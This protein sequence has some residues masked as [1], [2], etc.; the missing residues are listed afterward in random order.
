MLGKKE[1]LF[2]P[3][4]SLI[5]KNTAPKT[6]W[7]YSHTS[8]KN[9]NKIIQIK[10]SRLWMSII[11]NRNKVN[12]YDG[13]GQVK[14][15]DITRDFCVTSEVSAWVNSKLLPHKNWYLL[16]FTN[17]LRTKY[18]LASKGIKKMLGVYKLKQLLTNK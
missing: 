18:T 7:L 9:E 10:E 12:K 1:H 8:W 13:Y 16:S 2:N 6:V 4:I 3:F 11:H 14:W 17:M 5:E 15:M